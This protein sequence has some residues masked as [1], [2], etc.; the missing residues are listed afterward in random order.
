MAVAYDAES[1]GAG[2]SGNFNWTHT[3][4]GTPK[5]IWVFVGQDT[6][7]TDEVTGVTYGG[8]AM[9]RVTTGSPTN[10][11]FRD[12]SGAGED[13]GEYCYFLGASIP[14]G[15]Q[16]VAVTVNGT[17]SLKRGY[18]GSV[19]AAADTEVVD[20]N[21]NT[22]GGSTTPTLGTLS[23]GG[24][25]CM[26]AMGFW[27]QRPATGNITP[28]AGWTARREDTIGSNTIAH[29]TYDTIASADVAADWT[30]DQSAGGDYCG[31]ALAIREV[32][33][34]GSTGKSTLVGSSLIT[35]NLLRRLV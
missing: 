34:G 23:L 15:A 28:S 25:T 31:L 11:V 20:C 30:H 35:S 26:V 21:S 16:T 7:L 8:T 9:T 17:G 1:R 10:P 32:A 24:R 3:P 27:S 4:V 13:G 2:G 14:T 19:T 12:G 29:Y 6:G 22:A 33:G 18:A 5:G